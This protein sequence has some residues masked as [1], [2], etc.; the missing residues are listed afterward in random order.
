MKEI[1][2]QTAIITYFGFFVALT[3]HEAAKAFSARALGDRSEETASRATINP[4]PHVS[5]FGTIIFPLMMLFSGTSILF[6][7]AKPLLVDTRYFKRAKRDINIV[8]SSGIIFNFG[9]AIIGGLC[10]KFGNLT[11]DRLGV[12]AAP[13]PQLL[14]SV[15]FA[16]IVIGVLNL[17]PFPNSDMWRL[18]L[19]NLPY[20]A[21]RKLESV[22]G[23]LSIIML[24]ALLFGFFHFL[25]SPALALFTI[26]FL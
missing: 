2:P 7:W 24:F 16:N 23:P 6:G 8:F 4:V 10:L 11:P 17:I 5:L 14:L 25:F 3:M 12:A 18:L 19:N 20:E 13:L 9:I 15:S 1:D 26:L 21:G 22:A